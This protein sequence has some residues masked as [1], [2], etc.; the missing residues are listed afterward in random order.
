M[1]LVENILKKYNAIGI[2]IPKFM[3]QWMRSNHAGETGAVWIYRGARCIFW[4][5]KIL[6]MSKEHI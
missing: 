1:I 3:I 5:K 6:K 2:N 4:N